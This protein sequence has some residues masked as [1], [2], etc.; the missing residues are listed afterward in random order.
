MKLKAFVLSIV[1]LFCVKI[2]YDTARNQAVE[3]MTNA[4]EHEFTT[5]LTDMQVS[6][7]SNSNYCRRV[8]YEFKELETNK[9]YSICLNESSGDALTNNKPIKV[10]HVL[11]NGKNCILRFKDEDDKVIL[12]GETIA[13]GE[14]GFS[15]LINKAIICAPILEAL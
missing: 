12:S 15:L 2:V 3:Q 10:D 11:Y 5:I 13:Y 8:N 4:L 9:K 14:K 1:V 6:K 7:S